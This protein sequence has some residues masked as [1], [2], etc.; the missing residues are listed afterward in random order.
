MKQYTTT[1]AGIELARL[2]GRKTPYTGE[3]IK[4]LA[5]DGRI[6]GKLVGKYW[7]TTDKS[8]V[9]FAKTLQTSLK[10]DKRFTRFINNLE[11]KK[12]D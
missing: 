7:T 1:E 2:L 8:L 5:K 11:V 3:H 12:E 10:H 9:E 4:N 6:K